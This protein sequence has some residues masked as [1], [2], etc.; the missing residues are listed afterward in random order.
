[1]ASCGRGSAVA[2]AAAVLWRRAA[3]RRGGRWASTAAAAP[4]PSPDPPS[5]ASP[6]AAP[7]S[8]AR[9]RPPPPPLPPPPPVDFED[10]REAFRS[11]SSAELARGL[12]VLGLCSFGPLVE[13]ASQLMQ[14]SQRLLGR[15]LFEKLMKMTFYGQFVAGEDQ[16]AIRPLIRHNRA[17]GVGSVLDYSVE[18]DLTPKEAEEKE[19]DSC[20]SAFEKETGKQREKRYS[21]HRK[22]GDRRDGVIS[23]RTYFYADEGK[24]DRHMDTFLKCVE[25]SGG[26]SDDGFSAIKLTALGR[27][28]FLLQFSEVLV[29]WRRFFHQLA[30]EQGKVGLAALETKLEVEKLQEALAKLGI[31]TR[32]ESQHW[33]TGEKL[34]G[35]GTVDL[36]DWNSLIDTR[37]EISKLLLIPNIKTGQLEP[38]LSHFTEEEEKQMKRMLQRMDVLAKQAVKMGVRLMVDA[39]QTYFQPAISRLTLEMQRK[40]N[41]EKPSIFNTYQCYLKDAYDNVTVDVELSRREGWHF[42]AKLVRG[43]YMEQERRRAADVGYEDPINATYE[44]TSKMYH[45]CLDYILEEIRHNRKANVMVASHNKDTVKFTLR[46]MADLGIHPSEN[47]IYFGQLLGMCDQITFPLGQAGFPVYKYVPYGPV[48]E[49]LP[50]LSRRAQENQGFMARAQEERAL[51]WVELKR[52]LFS[53]S[54]LS[55]PSPP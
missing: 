49:V 55:A 18:E 33:F 9:L 22:F 30:A 2:A 15:D 53:G 44:E 28:Q 24:C 23:A 43:A 35:S 7:E 21:V 3:L 48:H 8:E 45:R 13:N 52:R 46:R 10:A 42:G 5:A 47:K 36:L 26:S 19:L 6:V 20:T 11:K 16:E 27:P 50:Y 14:L 25:A 39:E 31:A 12:L 51:L 34:G 1:M 38:L 54:L 40:F 29:K 41:Q 37:T 32:A 17:F 4:E